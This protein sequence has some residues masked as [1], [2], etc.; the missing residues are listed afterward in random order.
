[1]HGEMAFS[2]NLLL[3]LPFAALALFWWRPRV[4]AL[5]RHVRSMA[6]LLHLLIAVKLKGREV[7]GSPWS[8]ADEFA[9]RVRRTP[10]RTAM[11]MTDGGAMTFLQVDAWSNKVARWAMEQNLK[12]NDVVATYMPSCCEFVVLWLGLAKVGVTAALVNTTLVGQSLSQAFETALD[13]MPRNRIIVFGAPGVDEIVVG[14]LPGVRFY[15]YL[16][17]KR[18][19]AAA[20]DG[21]D[22]G[23]GSSTIGDRGTPVVS[24]DEALAKCCATFGQGVLRAARHAVRYD[25]TLFLIYTSGTTGRAKASKITHL[26]FWSAATAMAVL[27]GAN[28]EDRIYCTLPLC[29]ASAGMMAV[30]TMMYAGTAL[31]IRPRFSASNFMIDCIAH[32]C[33]IVHYIGELMRYL[34]HTQPSPYD[35][36]SR[37]RVAFGNGLRPE[38]WGP[39][40]TRF[41]VPHV[42]EFYGSTEGNVN[43][44]NNT[45][46]VGA[47]GIV[48][49]YAS[50]LYPIKLMQWDAEAGALV[51][52]KDGRC[53][54]CGPGESGQLLGLI[55]PHDPSRAFDGYTD[56]RAT[57]AKVVRGVCHENDSFFVSGD[58]LRRDG[59]GYY[60]FVDRVGESFRWKGENVST[61]DVQEVG[62]GTW[63]EG[64]MVLLTT[65]RRT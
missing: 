16:G 49:W 12:P 32:R 8:V 62:W 63:T 26:R 14:A 28:E 5:A 52:G 20:A 18:R 56:A 13:G 23:I 35:R 57:S 30:G 9:I 11:M 34:L 19:A 55:N 53:V 48:P 21:G 50:F 61:C 40:Q 24:L 3:L 64:A 4:A 37:I 15:S 46:T 36:Q 42:V 39:F 6:T 25:S 65:D 43:L 45:G 31:V 10:T 41:A 44:F 47:I 58:I 51:R 29:H 60:Y 59:F 17:E 27:T 33:T 7:R 22:G 54:P 1:M 38:V 2:Y